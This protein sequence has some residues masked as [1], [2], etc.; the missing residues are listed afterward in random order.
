MNKIITDLEQSLEELKVQLKLRAYVFG[1]RHE[2]WKESCKGDEY[3]ATTI[4][5]E[6]KAAE[7]QTT[8]NDLKE[9]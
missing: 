5:L 2:A 6:N 7:L 3:Q 1:F 8:I 9:L 4:V